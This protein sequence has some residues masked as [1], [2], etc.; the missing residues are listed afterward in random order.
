MAAARTPIASSLPSSSVSR[1]LN[2][3]VTAS[4]APACD[5]V[6]DGALEA[7]DPDFAA[8]AASERLM[9]GKGVLGRGQDG[10]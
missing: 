2:T 9:P 4:S 10:G 5:Q 6:A 1:R 7:V 8:L 3:A